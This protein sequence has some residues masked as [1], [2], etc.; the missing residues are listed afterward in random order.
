[1]NL[2]FEREIK[3]R[4][5]RSGPAGGETR[6]TAKNN[7]SIIDL[8]TVTQKILK[9]QHSLQRRFSMICTWFLRAGLNLWLISDGV[10]HESFKG[11]GGY[12]S[13]WTVSRRLWPEVLGCGRRAPLLGK[14]V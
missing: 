12:S 4:A 6:W 10:G 13:V 7:L 1:M 8:F 14:G 5:N 3:Y 9:F 2:K 11:L